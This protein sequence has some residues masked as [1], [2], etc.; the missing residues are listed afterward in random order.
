MIAAIGDARRIL[1]AG[2]GGTHLF[3]DILRETDSMFE[4]SLRIQ[5][6]ASG[7]R[8]ASGGGSRSEGTAVLHDLRSPRSMKLAA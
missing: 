2:A 5:A 1:L 4:V 6:A 8:S 7:S 3:L